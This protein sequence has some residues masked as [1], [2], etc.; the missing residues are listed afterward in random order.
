MLQLHILEALFFISTPF[1]GFFEA[2]AQV[3]AKSRQIIGQLLV[4]GLAGERQLG[5]PFGRCIPS[6]GN[7][8]CTIG[9]K[10]AKF[11]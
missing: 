11:R 9:D 4:S 8:F 10:T 7:P 1:P 3:L 5:L 6:I 2:F